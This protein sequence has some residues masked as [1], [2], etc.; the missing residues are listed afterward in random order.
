MK[1]S[2]A[3][4]CIWNYHDWPNYGAD[5]WNVSHWVRGRVSTKSRVTMDRQFPTEM[6]I[7]P[8]MQ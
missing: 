7:T 5:P 4:M 8:A 3:C 6:D 2:G 1:E